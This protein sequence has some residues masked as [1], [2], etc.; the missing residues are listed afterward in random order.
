M[1]NKCRMFFFNFYGPVI[2]L[3]PFNINYSLIKAS[4]KLV[5]GLNLEMFKS[6]FRKKEK[7]R[8]SS[9]SSK[10]FR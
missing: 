6:L 8:V 3:T 1:E 7:E 5:F 10:R 9:K 2:P 4:P